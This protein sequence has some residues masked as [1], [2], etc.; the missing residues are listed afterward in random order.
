MSK[1]D[2]DART[3]LWKIISSTKSAMLTHRHG[4]GELHS[5]PLT[6]QNKELGEDSTLYFFVP[7]DGD[8][9]GHLAAGPNVNLAYANVD[10]DDYV[11][12]S[13][14]ASLI[15]D[16]ALKSSLFNTVA[17]AWFPAGANDPNLG[18]LAVRMEQVEF[19]KAKD[20]KAVQLLKMAASAVTGRPPKDIS[21]HRK[22]RTP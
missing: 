11:S 2:D 20:S 8:V 3:K 14:K 7:K 21:E 6:T 19:W 17:K 22:V 13:G 10:D 12:V 9:A 4:G 1:E 15:E 18:L 5:Q 16:Q